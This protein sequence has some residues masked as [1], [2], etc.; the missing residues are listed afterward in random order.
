MEI[1]YVHG[2]CVRDGSWWWH[3]T[4]AELE[5][6]GLSSTA[7]ALP[8]CGETGLAVGTGGPSLA[9]DV[10]AVRA[11]LASRTGDVV[12]VAHSY[13]SVVAAEAAAGLPG[14]RHVV[15][16]AGTLPEA[17]ESQSSFGDGTPAP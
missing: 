17:G 8:S 5:R 9:E 16:V 13:G 6:R 2:A 15:V 14:V 10:A 3:L 12:V 1:V 7:P 11:H 4:A